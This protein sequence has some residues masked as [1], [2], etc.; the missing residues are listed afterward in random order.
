MYMYD[1][2]VIGGGAAGLMAAGSAAERG[3]KVALLEKMEKPARK[4]RITGK[5]RCNLTNTKPREQFLEKIQTNVDF[6]VPSFTAFD[7]HRLM[8]FFEKKGVRLSTEQG[9]RVYPKSGKAW[10]IA[11]ALVEWCEEGGVEILCHSTVE[12]IMLLGDKVRGVTYRT[13]KGFVRRM[14]A[15]AVILATGGASYPAT[16]STGDGY[17]MAHALGHAIEP[18]RPSLV[19]L[20][21][22]MPDFDFLKGLLL[23]NVRVRLMVDGLEADEEF[24]E[25]SF[26]ARG[27]EGAVVLRLSRKAVDALIDGR[28]VE[29]IADLKPALDEETLRDRIGR[30]MELLTSE[31]VVADLMRKLMPKELLMPV[32]KMIGTHPKRSLATF[33]GDKTEALIKVLKNFRVPVSDYR[34]FGEAVVTAGG[35]SV[36]DVDPETL[37]SRKV[38]GLYFA[39]ELLDLDADTGGYNL[40]I[41]FSTGY[42]ASQ[43]KQLTIDN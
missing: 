29:L 36:A 16:G 41:A 3:L 38:K 22:D 27:V 39:G 12:S 8:K 42:L 18:I 1:L 4:I 6:F 24:G 34:P 9:D 19:P 33:D 10:D 30:E 23:R 25:M 28:R 11:E 26:S 15:P 37:E 20:E 32:T 5:G 35:V 17:A 21:S 43:L 40:Q 7:N 31:N 14:E 13:R 2:I